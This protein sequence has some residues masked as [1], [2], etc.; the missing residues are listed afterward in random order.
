MNR[1]PQEFQ[2]ILW[3]TNIK[4]L[5]LEKDKNY[6]IHQ[7]LLYGNLKQIKWLFKAYGKG[8]VRETFIKNPLPIYTRTVFHFVKNF[9]LGLK[10]KKLDE[11]KYIKNIVGSLK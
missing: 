1:I 5:D 11:K 3:S 10:D 2:A 6:I 8:K 9:I 7:V 4:N